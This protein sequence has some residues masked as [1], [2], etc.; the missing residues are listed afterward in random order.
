[1]LATMAGRVDVHKDGYDPLASK[2]TIDTAFDSL[3]KV[4]K[5]PYASLKYKIEIL[6]DLKKQGIVLIDVSPF[7]IYF[8]SETITRRNKKTGNEY[9]TPEFKLDDKD[10][11]SIISTAFEIYSGPFLLDIKPKN[12]L[13][14][15]KKVGNVLNA[16]GMLQEKLNSFGG[17]LLGTM[18]HPSSLKS[19]WGKN[20]VSN[21]KTLR[22][23]SLVTRGLIPAST[24][25]PVQIA[26][27]R[28][29][30]S[31][32]EGVIGEKRREDTQEQA[33]PLTQV[34]RYESK[35]T[36]FSIVTCVCLLI[37]TLDI[38]EAKDA[39]S[40]V[41]GSDEVNVDV[42]ADDAAPSEPPT[43]KGRQTRTSQ[44]ATLTKA[45]HEDGKWTPLH[46]W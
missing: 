12:V 19:F 15:G 41:L 10:Y 37:L 42:V 21:L 38:I 17:N 27:S 39:A 13:V 6:K 43:K 36:L 22:H 20:A 11:K 44:K 8:G 7:A 2:E 18:T 9:W 4:T 23:Y 14:L 29:P 32:Q 45:L 5:N 31:S 46:K 26:T 1:M 16:K 33:Q 34:Y 35:M 28:A 3:K 25:V 40:P 24:P 30:A